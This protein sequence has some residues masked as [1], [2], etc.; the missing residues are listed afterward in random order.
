[1]EFRD[2]CPKRSNDVPVEKNYRKYRPL[3]AEDFG[4]RCGYCND[5]DYIRKENFEIDHFIPK[6]KMVRMKDNDY[7]NLV[8]VCR[9]CNNAKRAKWPSGDENI[10]VVGNTGWLDPCSEE[11]GIQFERTD[12]G[13]IVPKTK[14]GKWMYENL[15]LGKTLHEYLW[16]IEQLHII[17]D[18]FE[19]K[20]DMNADNVEFNE[21]YFNCL[22]RYKKEIDMLFN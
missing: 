22:R 7:N 15:N 6:E 16:N 2:K 20:I 12:T 21:K 13:A 17:C 18:D 11:Y 5:W 8:Y 1:M 3:L 19:S 9:S 14:L 4:H 10:S